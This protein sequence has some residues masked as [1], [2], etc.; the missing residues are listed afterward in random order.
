MAT[1]RAVENRVAIARAA[2]TG[3]SAFIDPAGRITR[4]TS[5]FQ[6]TTLSA[7]VPLMH[8]KT[9]YTKFGDIFPM[10]CL[11]MMCCG[12]C[13]KKPKDPYQTRLIV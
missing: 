11:L 4:Q 10:I 13:V 3:I 5:L 12:M 9:W 6:A 7:S 1:F 2:N 8:V